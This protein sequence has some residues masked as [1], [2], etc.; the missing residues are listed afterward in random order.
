M[1][2]IGPNEIECARCGGISHIEE[3]RC[4]H[5]G[6]SI[7]EPEDEHPAQ[8]NSALNNV[9][10][11]LRQP[12]AIFSGW[13]IAAFIGLLLY[14]PIRLAGAEAPSQLLLTL[15]VT[16]TLS[17]GAFSGSFLYQRIQQGK[18]AFGNISQIGLSVLIGVLIFITEGGSVLLWTAFSILALGIIGLASFLGIKIAD[19]MLRQAMINDLFAPVVESQQRYQDLLVK[20]GH[21]REVAERLIEHE[22]KITPKAT[23]KLLIE[24]AIKRWMR[25]NRAQ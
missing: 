6:V 20:I 4:P 7:Y 1:P 24:N 2:E 9:K 23:R 18:S 12:F 17:L 14:I 5:C 19:K 21:D 22:R 10:N 13:F 15:L 3:T 16:G 8:D 25:D 11:A